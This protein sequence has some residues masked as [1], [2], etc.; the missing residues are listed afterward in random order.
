MSVLRSAADVEYA[1]LLGVP[2]QDA[3]ARRDTITYGMIYL[4][5]S[6]LYLVYPFINSLKK[7]Y[8]NSKTKGRERQAA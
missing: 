3:Q 5:L 2:L 6:V 8:E 4:R 7:Y 1:S